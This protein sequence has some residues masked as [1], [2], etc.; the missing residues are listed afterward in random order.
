MLLL[1][2]LYSE[3]PSSQ[4]AGA[5][6]AEALLRV[7]GALLPAAVDEVWS[8]ALLSLKTAPHGQPESLAV[9]ADFVRRV[10]DLLTQV[11]SFLGYS[12]HRADDG[13][14]SSS[15]APL[16]PLTR[17]PFPEEGCGGVPCAASLAASSWAALGRRRRRRR[18]VWLATAAW[19]ARRQGAAAPSP[20]AQ[21]SDP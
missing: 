6:L 16:L 5:V 21:L 13:L 12:H 20:A 8:W 14:L 17:L 2:K 15:A 11:R 1:R 19:H 3:Q 7:N 4:E 18:R 9:A 10:A